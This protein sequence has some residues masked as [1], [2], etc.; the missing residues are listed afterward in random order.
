MDRRPVGK[1]LANSNLP[2]FSLKDDIATVDSAEI[3]L[4]ET[5]REAFYSS[6]GNRRCSMA[7]NCENTCKSWREKSNPSMTEKELDSQTVARESRGYSRNTCRWQKPHSVIVTNP[8][9][10]DPLAP[11]VHKEPVG[12]DRIHLM[13]VPSEILREII[14]FRCHQCLRDK[15]SKYFQIDY[16]RL[17]SYLIK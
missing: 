4:D 2:D 1:A 5:N 16:D 8:T 14:L 11:Q 15:L 9:L 13:S 6:L 10:C 12:N 17:V 3:P 7:M